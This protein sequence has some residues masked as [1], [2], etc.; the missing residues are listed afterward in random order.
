[1]ESTQA[2]IQW[3]PGISPRAEWP[4]REFDHSRPSSGQAKN[5]WICISAPHYT[6]TAWTGITLPLLHPHKERQICLSLTS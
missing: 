3:V 2:P 4:G 1:M 6:F 5:M